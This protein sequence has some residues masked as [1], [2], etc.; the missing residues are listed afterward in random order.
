[1]NL[2]NVFLSFTTLIRIKEFNLHPFLF[3][4]QI[5]YFLYTLI[6]GYFLIQIVSIEFRSIHNEMQLRALL[7]HM[8]F[9]SAPK[10]FQTQRVNIIMKF[11]LVFHI[12]EPLSIF[13][14]ILFIF[15][16]Y[17][18]G[19]CD[20][21]KFLSLQHYYVRKIDGFY[22]CCPLFVGEESNLPKGFIFLFLY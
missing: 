2:F 15:S 16:I 3:F 8:K 13:L 11:D 7:N 20:H 12:I 10:A 14:Y 21:Q 18:E 4:P 17:G 9:R 6:L 22:G 5:A 1:M 19:V